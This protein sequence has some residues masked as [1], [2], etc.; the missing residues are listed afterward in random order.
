M[1]FAARADESSYP[2]FLKIAAQEKVVLQ[3]FHVFLE[4]VTPASAWVTV[5]FRVLVVCSRLLY[6]ALSLISSPTVPWPSSIFPLTEFKCAVASVAFNTACWLVLR[7]S[8][9]FFSMSDM[10]RGGMLLI[11][12]RSLRPLDLLT[13][14]KWPCIDCPAALRFRLKPMSLA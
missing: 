4:S 12:S 2:R 6:N 9:A 13:Q 10:I 11:V 1:L 5:S 8:L 3:G 14:M 7:I